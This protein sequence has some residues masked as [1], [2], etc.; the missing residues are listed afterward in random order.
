MLGQELE[1][2]W[3]DLASRAASLDSTEDSQVVRP[4]NEDADQAGEGEDEGD[5]LEDEEREAR[6]AE[7]LD[8]R[9][10][11]EAFME[12]AVEAFMEGPEAPAINMATF[13]DSSAPAALVL[14]KE[15]PS[16]DEL[17]IV[18]AQ[19]AAAAS[20]AGPKA[21]KDMTDVE[22]R[23]RLWEVSEQLKRHRCH[24]E[25]LSVLYML[26]TPKTI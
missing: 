17:Q 21:H 13:S 20:T 4:T 7:R 12:P 26:P 24:C 19:V 8:L 9:P 11:F 5:A 18:S 16:D 22:P 10:A 2:Q 15:D 6:G 25:S 1:E 14:V 3:A 23:T